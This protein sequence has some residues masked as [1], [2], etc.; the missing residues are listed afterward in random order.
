MDTK[1][2]C[3]GFP[4]VRGRYYETFGVVELQQTFYQLSW[5]GPP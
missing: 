1:V 5:S 3:C 2:G 4:V